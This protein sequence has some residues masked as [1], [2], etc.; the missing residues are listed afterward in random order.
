MLSLDNMI[1]IS[2]KNKGYKRIIYCYWG[3]NTDIFFQ[4]REDKKERGK[5]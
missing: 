5:N 2:E 3:G 4:V 1:D